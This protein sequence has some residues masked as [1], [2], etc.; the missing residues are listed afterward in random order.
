[1]SLFDEEEYAEFPMYDDTFFKDIGRLRNTLHAAAAKETSH[2]DWTDAIQDGETISD[3]INRRL[4]K[5]V[6]GL[7][8]ATPKSTNGPK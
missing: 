8:E 2:L 3:D 7:D 4:K 5:F 1:M 6:D